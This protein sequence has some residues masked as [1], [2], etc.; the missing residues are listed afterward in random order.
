MAKRI[1][2]YLVEK[3]LAESRQKA[4]ALIAGGSV[5]VNSITVKK[6]SYQVEEG[7][8]VSVVEQLK[9]VGR[10]GYKLEGALRAFDLNLKDLVCADIGASTGGFT[11][12]MLQNGARRVY[13]IDSGHGQLDPRL[14]A[15]PDVIN[16]EGY[17]IRNFPSDTISPVDF[18]AVDLSFISLTLVFEPICRLMKENASA[19]FLIKPQFEAGREWVGKGIVQNPKV[20]QAVLEKTI[21]AAKEAGFMPFGLIPSPITGGDGNIEFLLYVKT[22]THQ[23]A[24]F[25]DIAQVV[26]KAH[27][28]KKKT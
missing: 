12:C 7:A 13:A 28:M 23:P 11:D 19:V 25:I 16:L 20:H 17:N 6:P 15:H 22:G 3:K 21:L 9:Y 27:E 4:Q 5:K 24:P 18:A 8:D 26:K 14:D 10:G 1:D 2:V